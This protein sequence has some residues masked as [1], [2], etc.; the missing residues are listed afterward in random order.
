[1]CGRYTLID[2]QQALKGVGINIAVGPKSLAAQYNIAPSQLVPVIT[3]AAPQELTM[4]RWGLIPSWAKDPKIGYT[5]IN[6]RAETIAEKPTFKRLF[7]KQRCLVL[8]DG[9]FEWQQT[10]KRKVPHWIRLKSGAPFSF[11]GLW[12]AWEDPGTRSSLVTFTIITTA[13][14]SLLQAIHE[15]MPVILRAEEAKTWLSPDLAEGKA[16]AMLKSLPASEMTFSEI[17]TLVN[18]PGNN[19]PEVIQ[20]TGTPILRRS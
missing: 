3:N 2:L 14:N 7:K 9:F 16:L 20:P 11:A 13:A 6:A 17:S 12:D 8:A 1:M 10:G 4:A 19:I 18:S 5:M 15:R